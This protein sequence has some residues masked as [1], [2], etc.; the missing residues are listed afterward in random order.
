MIDWSEGEV[1]WRTYTLCIESG[2]SKVASF[3]LYKLTHGSLYQFFNGLAELKSF[4]VLIADV[5]A[6]TILIPEKHLFTLSKRA[7][8]EFYGEILEMQKL[9]VLCY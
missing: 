4:L 9:K 5:Y 2:S 3:I 8:Q 6:V 1:I 7:M